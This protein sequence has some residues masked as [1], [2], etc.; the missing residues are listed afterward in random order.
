V[1]FG[2]WPVESQGKGR[3]SRVRS[4]PRQRYF[5]LLRNKELHKKPGDVQERFC[6]NYYYQIAC[7]QELES[8]KDVAALAALLSSTHQGMHVHLNDR[9]MHA[10]L[11]ST[12]GSAAWR[13]VAMWP[14]RST[15]GSTTANVQEAR[16]CLKACRGGEMVCTVSGAGSQLYCGELKLTPAT[17]LVLDSSC[18]GVVMSNMHI[19]GAGPQCRRFTTEYILRKVKVEYLIHYR[20]KL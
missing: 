19:H 1:K 7:T 5:F 13:S 16:M 14:S 18:S 8:A 4:S 15:P 6:I 20:H 17:A 2:V 10:P 11:S 9:V 12:P 3:C